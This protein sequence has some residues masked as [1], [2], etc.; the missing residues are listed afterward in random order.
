ML[1]VILIIARIH[2]LIEYYQEIIRA[3]SD[4]RHSSEMMEIKRRKL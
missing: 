3:V 1:A 4:S 2:G